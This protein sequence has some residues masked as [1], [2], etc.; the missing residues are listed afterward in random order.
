[1]ST[2]IASQVLGS[3]TC[4]ELW[5]AVKES[6]LKMD[7]YLRKIKVLSNN[8]LAGSPLNTDDLIT[9]TLANPDAEYNA[10]VVQLAEKVGLTWVE[11]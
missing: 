7:E 5:N 2:E 6:T 4:Q 9:Q 8:L 11:L 1:M 3:K 10:V